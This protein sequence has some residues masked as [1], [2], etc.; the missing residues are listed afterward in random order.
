[1]R[2]K[3]TPR[4]HQ[5]APPAPDSLIVLVAH[6]DADLRA[7]VA[8]CLRTR[9]PS[10]AWILG[11]ATGAEAMIQAADADLI[12]TDYLMQGPGGHDIYTTLAADNVL[13]KIPVLIL[14]DLDPDAFSIP[15]SPTMAVLTMPFYARTLLAKVEAP[16]RER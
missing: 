12:I 4:S 6:A 14:A 7:Y 16:L 5:R 13:R 11:A 3:N 1:M 10:P 2:A 8:R 9:Q 15:E